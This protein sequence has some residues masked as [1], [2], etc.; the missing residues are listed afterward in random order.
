MLTQNCPDRHLLSSVYRSRHIMADEYVE[1][2]LIALMRE[3]GLLGDLNVIDLFDHAP[4]PFPFEIV[5]E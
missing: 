2:A 4:D 1:V 3:D 5:N